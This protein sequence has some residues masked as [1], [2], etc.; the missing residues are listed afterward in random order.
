MFLSP[1]SPAVWEIQFEISD[2]TGSAFTSEIQ[3][4]E[5]CPLFGGPKGMGFGNQ[6]EKPFRAVINFDKAINECFR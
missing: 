5:S 6:E 4:A 1:F 3:C 2:L